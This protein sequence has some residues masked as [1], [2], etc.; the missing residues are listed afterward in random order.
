MEQ[1]HNVIATNSTVNSNDTTDNNITFTAEE[2]AGICNFDT[3]DPLNFEAIDHRL[4]FYNTWFADTAT[5]SHI[6]NMQNALVNFKPLMK[7]IN[8]V[9]NATTLAKGKGTIEIETQIEQKKFL[10]MLENVLYIPLNP[11]N[12]LFLGCWDNTGGEY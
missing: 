12:L 9:G 1:T 6:T 7:P 8:G 10:L 5:T 11:H 3:Y 2:L 4:I